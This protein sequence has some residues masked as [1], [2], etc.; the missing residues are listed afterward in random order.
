MRKSVFLAT[1]LFAVQLCVAEPVYDLVICGSSSAGIAAAVEAKRHGLRAVVLSATDRIGGLTT[2]GLGQT[3]IGLKDAFGGIAR[4]FYRAVKEHY[5]DPSNWKWQK[6]EDYRP[7][8]QSV[9]SR[10]EDAMWTFEPSAALAILEGWERRDG[11]DIRRGERLDR[12]NGG[13]VKE[14]GR[15]VAVRS[16]S[17]KLYRGRYFVDATYEGDL[18]AA[19]GC[20]YAVGREANSVYGET[21]SGIQR[22]AATAHQFPRGIDPYVVK[23]DPSSGLLPGVE[24]DDPRPDGSGDRRVQAY[25]FRMC[26]TDV[27]ENRIPFKKPADYDERLYELLFR[28]LESGADVMPQTPAGSPMPNRKTDTNNGLAFSSDFIGQ[29]YDWPE[30][31]YAERDRIAARH[32]SYQQGLMWTCAYHPR[33]PKRV[34]DLFSKWGTCRDEFA[35]ERGDGWQEQIYVREGRRLVGETV[36]TEAHCRQLARPARP[37]AKGA[38]SMD[39]HHVRRYVTK[40][41]DVQNEG[42]VQDWRVARP[43]DIDYGAIVPKRSECR[44]LLVPICLSASHMAYGSIRMEPVFFALGHVAAAAVAV[45]AKTDADVQDADYGELAAILKSEG[46]VF[47]TGLVLPM[48]FTDHAVLPRDRRM[49]VWGTDEPGTTVTVSFGGARATAKADANG[50]WRTSL[51]PMP[52]TSN[53]RDFVVEGTTSVTLRNVVVGDVW[54]ITGPSSLGGVAKTPGRYPGFPKGWRFRGRSPRIASV[55]YD[56]YFRPNF[57]PEMHEWRPAEVEAGE[58]PLG[59]LD[60]TWPQV[61]AEKSA[62]GLGGEPTLHYGMACG[63]KDIPVHGAAWSGDADEP[64]SAALE[65]AWRSVWPDICETRIPAVSAKRKGRAGK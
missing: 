30:A 35:G 5:S 7:G 39:S 27:E 14:D 46:Q 15:I 20:S 38:Y 33:T 18:L 47:G 52:A 36:M 2:G 6:S 55:F 29:N 32:L 13:V 42:D 62:P 16:E 51:P 50:Q 53:G 44:N 63:F 48:Y 3:D 59:V 54:Y 37:V 45:A 25:C 64:Q 8:G 9:Y 1:V 19:A 34:R 31:S 65:A 17:G 23:G 49:P 11:L 61:T 57:R 26:L 4:E 24:R 58:V 43:Y 12:G 60:A 28:W 21:V 22:R 56:S 40:R 41:G 10:N